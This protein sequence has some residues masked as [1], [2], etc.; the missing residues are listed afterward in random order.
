MFHA[1][2]ET[3]TGVLASAVNENEKMGSETKPTI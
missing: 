1:W 3:F 2:N